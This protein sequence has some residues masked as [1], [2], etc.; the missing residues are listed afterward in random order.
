MPPKA[1]QVALVHRVTGHNQEGGI[2]M[3]SD[4]DQEPRTFHFT[5]AIA[6]EKTTV[7]PDEV[8]GDIPEGTYPGGHVRIEKHQGS[9]PKFLSWHATTSFTMDFDEM[10]SDDQL[11]NGAAGDLF[12]AAPNVVEVSPGNFVCTA[13]LKDPPGNQKETIAYKYAVKAGTAATLDPLIIVDR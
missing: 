12:K 1:C 8:S 9:A 7:E 3:L 13:E 6:N 10:S 4:R 5:V 11:A 2:A